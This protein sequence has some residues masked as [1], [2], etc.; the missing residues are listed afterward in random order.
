MHPNEYD[1][2]TKYMQYKNMENIQNINKEMQRPEKPYDACMTAVVPYGY[3]QSSGSPASTN[4]T[5]T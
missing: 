3:Q 4:L 1:K 5:L 2:E